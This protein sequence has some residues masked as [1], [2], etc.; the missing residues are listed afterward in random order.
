MAFPFLFLSLSLIAGILFS[1]LLFSSLLTFV[2]SFFFLLFIA[3][4]FFFLKRYRFS[5]FCLLL[6]TF[7][8]GAGLHTL[9]DKNFEKN[10]LHNLK[11]KDYADFYGSLSKSPSKGQNKDILFLKVD[12]VSYLNREEKIQGNLRVNVYHSPY[13][14]R[15]YDLFVGDK[16]KV[17][18]RLI[19]AKG[20]RN[21]R[22]F[23]M[24]LY[25]KS[26]KIH[27][28]A[29]SKSPL[30]VE[31]TKSG[32]TF[33]LPR[34]ISIIRRGLQKKIEKHFL[35]K[36]S[37]LSSQGAILEALLL[38]ERG[39]MDDS[40]TR[41]LQNAG[42]YHLFAISGAH[43]A[44]I[45]FFLFS[46]LKLL[47]IPKRLSYL[48]L[49]IFLIFYALLV[50]GRPSVM[51]ATIMALAFF[52]GKIIWSHVSL[53]NTLSL[54]AF[55]LLLLNPY[56][57]FSV[58]FQLT[59]AATLSIILF[60]PRII[61]YMPKLPLRISEIF[62]LSLTAQLGIMPII[63]TVFHRITFSSLILNY[64]A[65][66]LVGVIMACGYIFLP[67]SLISSFIGQL[68]AEALGYL[69]N[70][71]IGAS[72]LLDWFPSLSYRIPSP[73]FLLTIGYFLLLLLMLLPK[74]MKRQKIICLSLFLVSFFL[75]IS[76]P[77]PS[78]TKDFK[79]TLIDVGQGESILVEFPGKKKML[80]DG[81]G[82]YQGTFDIGER[83]VSPFLWEKGIKKL[84]YLVLTHAHPDHLKGL[85]AVARNFKIREFW[86][87]FSP[88][89][90]EIYG[91]FKNLLPSSTYRRRLFRGDSHQESS[92]RIEILHPERGVFFVPSVHND[93]S[94]VLRLL[95]L[96]TAF[97]L[98]G[99][100]GREAETNIL[101]NSLNI[102]S[103]VLKS[104]H[105]GSNS[106]SSTGFLNE[107]KPQ[108]VIISIGEKNRYGFPDQEVLE[109]Y[110][111]LGAKV[112]RT[113]L[114]GAIE[115]SSDGHSI[116]IRTASDGP[117]PLIQVFTTSKRNKA[118]K[119]AAAS[120]QGHLPTH[121]LTEKPLFLIMESGK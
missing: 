101:K 9:H 1:H 22:G 71:L 20:F 62:V 26:Q 61:K 23:S 12:K 117:S 73:Y 47:Q 19:S 93:Q 108:L 64:A 99:D 74:K 4:L 85:R 50:E 11:H 53:I 84:D 55:V 102:R 76:Y 106:S 57:L 44:I 17:S 58:G 70:L 59:F 38:G 68:L 10:F 79:L 29:S 42:I 78:Q 49:M 88:V 116:S 67:F 65:L 81:G 82:L 40:V 25:L 43:I 41:S 39:R 114:C 18:A 5:F 115:L 119:V 111:K 51:R 32:N 28:R 87:A 113:D 105:H 98:T 103:Q 94:L 95:Y 16:I 109:R 77:F 15:L 104:P 2:L 13:S 14:S 54:S 30:L 86:E 21:F 107:V 90:N 31:K 27:N 6:S 91:E 89:E 45:S 69:I 33:S 92:V 121:H 118:V 3:W 100:I 46:L 120:G 96:Q 72:R 110:A 97:L 48:L 8:L 66:P 83:V 34:L 35:S 63:A 60:F 56:S 75:L 80:I 52:L 37:A 112:Y 36:S 24:D 7:L